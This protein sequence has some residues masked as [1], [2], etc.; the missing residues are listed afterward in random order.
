MSHQK[1]EII[2]RLGTD[3]EM[4]YS[5]SGQPV[6]NF[7][8]ATNR[9]YK[10]AAGQT[11]KETTWFKVSAWG[12]M[13]EACNSYLHKGSLVYVEGRLIADPSTGSPR[14]WDRQDGTPAASFELHA[15]TVDFLDSK[16]GDANGHAE[17]LAPASSENEIP[18]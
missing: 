4:R 3:P 6:T 17:Q 14:I 10:N 12:K 2:G 18:F 8:V 1:C 5:P 9:K 15:D 13:A 7:P 16:N 11:V